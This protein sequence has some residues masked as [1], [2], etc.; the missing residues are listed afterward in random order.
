MPAII[1]TIVVVALLL[2]VLGAI[3]RFSIVSPLRTRHANN[4]LRDPD[5]AGVERICGFPPP[6]D[7]VRL[8]RDGVLIDRVELSLVDESKQPQ[9]TWFIGGFYPLTARDVS[10]QRKVHGI[11]DGIPIADDLDKGVYFVTRD[12]RIMFR[13]PGRDALTVEVAPSATAL[14]RFTRVEGREE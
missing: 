14:S 11:S 7:L 3:V 6:A 1:S 4:R 12:G 2:L 10:E 9:K 5:I 13:P 8:Y